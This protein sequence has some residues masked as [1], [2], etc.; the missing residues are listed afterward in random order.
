MANKILKQIVIWTILQ[1]LLP[2][3]SIKFR[4]WRCAHVTGLKIRYRCSTIILELDVEATNGLNQVTA[5]I[6]VQL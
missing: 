5:Y 6:A 3:R 4:I 1:L 2:Y